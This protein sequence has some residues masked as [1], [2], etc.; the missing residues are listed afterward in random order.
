LEQ[1]GLIALVFS[2]FFNKKESPYFAQNPD[3]LILKCLETCNAMMNE[4]EIK[5]CEGIMFS[6]SQEQIL[7]K[8]NS[9]PGMEE[10]PG[11]CSI[12]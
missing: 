1:F 11:Y 8:L 9:L 6:F 2:H 10:P 3:E 4:Y 5:K 7:Q 12:A